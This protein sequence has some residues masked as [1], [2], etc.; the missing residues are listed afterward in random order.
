MFDSGMPGTFLQAC[1]HHSP[2]WTL[3]DLFFLFSV[4]TVSDLG[5]EGREEALQVCA[6]RGHPRSLLSILLPLE[7]CTDF[8]RR[9]PPQAG[10]RL[11]PWSSSQ[12]LQELYIVFCCLNPSFQSC[13]EHL[14]GETRS[15][16]KPASCTRRNIQNGMFSP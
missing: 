9:N 8:M 7:Q 13:E 3:L 14:C 10:A 1:C 15:S 2:G 16:E 5:W 6:W 4:V 12:T 11:S